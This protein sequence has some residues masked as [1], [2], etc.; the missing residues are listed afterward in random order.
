MVLFCFVFFLFP[1]GIQSGTVLVLQVNIFRWQKTDGKQWLQVCLWLCVLQPSKKINIH[2]ET[3]RILALC[4]VAAAVKTGKLN[5]NK[6]KEMLLQLNTKTNGLNFL[7]CVFDAI[8]WTMNG[9][10]AGGE[11]DEDKGEFD[12]LSKGWRRSPWNCR[13]RTEP[14][15]VCVKTCPDPSEGLLPAAGP[16][17]RGRRQR[18][19]IHFCTSE[20]KHSH[21]REGRGGDNSFTAN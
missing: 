10:E 3:S 14:P 6:R 19:K 21:Y 2:R 1:R 20:Y 15:S 17:A 9:T 8:L 12:G 18:A 16:E 4:N 7:G 11:E 13:L 5:P